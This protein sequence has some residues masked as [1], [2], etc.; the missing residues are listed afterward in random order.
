VTALRTALA[1]LVLPIALSACAGARSAAGDAARSAARQVRDAVPA[2]PRT[3]A[4][5]TDYRETSSHADVLAFIDSMHA[6]GAAREAM[7]VDTLGRSPAGRVLP[8][9]IV[10]RPRVRTPEEARA[11][12]RPIVWVQANIHAGEV[13]GKEA[14]QAVL[15][16]LVL[17]RW[18]NVLDSIVLVAV[19]IYNADGNEKLAAQ[20]RNRTE[21][22]G[23]EQVGER[24][25]GQGLDLNRDYVKAETPE[26]RA[27]LAAFRRWDPDVF[28]DLHTTDGSFHGYALTYSPSLHPAAPLGPWTRDTLLPEL[29]ASMRARHGFE[30]FDYG[31]FTTGYGDDVNTD[32]LKRGWW[33]YEHVP[34]FGTNYY[35]LRNRVAIL[36]E[37]FSHDPFERRVKATDAFVREVLSMAARHGTELRSR[38]RN[39]DIVAQ[40]P[41]THRVPVAARVTTQ[42]VVQP[43]IA[44]DLVVDPDSVPDE[45]GVPR[46]LRRTGRFRTLSMPTYLTFDATAWAAPSRGW[47]IPAGLDT[48]A[49]LL[50]AHGVE[51][52]RLASD[53]TLLSL[54]DVVDSVVVATRP[55]Q[56]HR[57]IRVVA[58]RERKAVPGAYAAGSWFVPSSQRLGALA[59]V[60]L[61]VASDDGVAT[62]GLLGERLRPGAAFPV[63]EVVGR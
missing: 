57:L 19:P 54:P 3:R 35:G 53:T 55:F 5:R 30:T 39:A 38:G 50:E 41:G 63:V 26:T 7:V 52:R 36:S 14:L 11:T 20:S 21:Q 34:R 4:E 43:V 28:V 16:D 61:S 2:G 49:Q 25:N 62:W 12:G 60:L 6:I 46:G 8:L 44:E 37:A 29:R 22:N 13:E 23:P 40:Q 15:R 45:P 24:A 31:N 18:S 1:A 48:V 56:G 33:T 58:H 17:Y 51:L 27:S 47:V 9:V 10:S 59:A 42:G 32:T